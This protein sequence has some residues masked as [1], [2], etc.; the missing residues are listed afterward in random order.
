[1]DK[2]KKII[3]KVISLKV[4]LSPSKKKN[5]F[6]C[7]NESP[8]KIMKNTFYLNLKALFVLKLLKIFVLTFWPSRKNPLIIKISTVW[9]VS[10]N[11]I[12]SGPYFPVFRLN[13]DIYSVNLCIQFKYRKIPTQKTPYLD[14]FHAVKVNFKIYDVTTWLTN[15]CNTL[16]SKIS[17]SKDNHTMK[18]GQVIEHNKINIFL[19][20]SCRKWSRETSSRPHF[21]F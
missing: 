16:L 17:Q 21:I 8:L 19:Q 20:K 7:F 2:T 3:N 18:F 4:D 15:N 12:F 6:L 5:C 1:M 11:R 13:M 14:T 9:K 10:K